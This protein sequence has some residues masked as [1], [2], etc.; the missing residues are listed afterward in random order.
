MWNICLP[1]NM[2]I[3]YFS[4]PFSCLNYHLHKIDMLWDTGVFFSKNTTDTCLF[5]IHL[6]VSTQYS[7]ALTSVKYYFHLC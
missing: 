5:Q 2:S 7:L 3:L 1:T 6:K 4:F